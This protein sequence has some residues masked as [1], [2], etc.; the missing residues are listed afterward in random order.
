MEEWWRVCTYSAGT[1]AHSLLDITSGELGAALGMHNRCR[2]GC[3]GKVMLCCTAGM[4]CMSLLTEYLI[5]P[6]S[7][8][9]REWY[10]GHL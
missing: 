8:S 2:V 5:C 4:I 10:A 3:I 6:G 1:A 7:S 9:L